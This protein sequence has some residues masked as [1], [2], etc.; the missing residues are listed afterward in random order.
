MQITICRK[1]EGVSAGSQKY[2]QINEEQ[3]TRLISIEKK[4]SERQRLLLR[5]IRRQE[6]NWK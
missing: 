2:G 4:N 5:P 3:A 6:D 1:I